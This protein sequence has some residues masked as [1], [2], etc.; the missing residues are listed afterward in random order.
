LNFINF[1]LSTGTWLTLPGGS[2]VLLFV[3]LVKVTVLALDFGAVVTVE[4][5]K[6]YQIQGAGNSQLLNL[7][8]QAQVCRLAG[9]HQ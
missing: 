8:P 3:L 7:L 5:C 1:I 4:Q 9:K 6:L 2:V